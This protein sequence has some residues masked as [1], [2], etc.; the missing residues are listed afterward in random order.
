MILAA[1][2]GA[3]SALEDELD[4]LLSLRDSSQALI[5]LRDRV[6]DTLNPVDRCLQCS[7]HRRLRVFFL[8][9]SASLTGLLESNVLAHMDCIMLILFG[10]SR[11]VV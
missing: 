5:P 1:H 3:F 6:S 2:A 8:R 7:S 9:L 11:V 4:H 10:R